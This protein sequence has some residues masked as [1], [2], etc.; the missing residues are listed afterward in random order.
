MSG[1]AV[2]FLYRW[3]DENVCGQDLG[4]TSAAE[5]AE[6]TAADAAEQGI[7]ISETEADLGSIAAVV[8]E[9][10]AHQDGGR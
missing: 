1:K 4:W 3:I 9:A 10:I 5:L 8:F 6:Q 2:D 7:S